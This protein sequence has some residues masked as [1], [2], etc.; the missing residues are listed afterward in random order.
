MVLNWGQVVNRVL[1]I[2]P[3]YLDI[4]YNNTLLSKSSINGIMTG[5][6][7]RCGEKT[8]ENGVPFKSLGISEKSCPKYCENELLNIMISSKYGNHYTTFD[9]RTIPT[10]LLNNLKFNINK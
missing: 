4:S 7:K 10:P 8:F 9:I 1:R 2:K 3:G 6:I 5:T